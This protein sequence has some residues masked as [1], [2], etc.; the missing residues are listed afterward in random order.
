V[1]VTTVT[2][3]DGRKL[4]YESKTN[5]ALRSGDVVTLQNGHPAKHTS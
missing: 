5:P 1:W 4:T 2:W 3:K